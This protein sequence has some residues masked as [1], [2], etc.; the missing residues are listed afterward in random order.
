MNEIIIVLS[1][2]RN[3]GGSEDVKSALIELIKLARTGDRQFVVKIKSLLP[4]IMETLKHSEV[5]CPII[6]HQL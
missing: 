5:F 2:S 3:A 1:A 6:L 4:N